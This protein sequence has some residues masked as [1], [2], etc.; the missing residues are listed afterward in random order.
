LKAD[1][2]DGIAE[3]SK[4][5]LQQ[6]NTQRE[7]EAGKVQEGGGEKG[8][9]RG[10]ELGVRRRKAKRWTEERRVADGS[11]PRGELTTSLG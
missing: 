4:L 1:D 5:E 10:N 3:E 6:E 2:D 9:R 7:R 11:A 8:Q